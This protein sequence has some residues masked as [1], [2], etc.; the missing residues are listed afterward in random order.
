MTPRE[1]FETLTSQEVSGPPVSAQPQAARKPEGPGE[2]EAPHEQ[3]TPGPV[4]APGPTL[5]PAMK[6]GLQAAM[7][8]AMQVSAGPVNYDNRTIIYRI[9]NPVT[10]MN[11]VDL[12]IEPPIMSA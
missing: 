8:P 1:K 5:G 6:P 10:G 2:P 7:E 4:P 11:K 9:V 3:E 12:L